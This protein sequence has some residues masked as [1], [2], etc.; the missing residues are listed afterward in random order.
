MIELSKS[1]KYTRHVLFETEH[2]EIVKCEWDQNSVSA[3]HSHGSSQCSVLVEEGVFENKTVMGFKTEIETLKAGEVFTTPI[4][5][6]HEIRCVSG[7]GKT[8]HVYSPKIKKE[9]SNEEI[10]FKLDSKNNNHLDLSLGESMTWSQVQKLLNQI[11]SASVTTKSPYFMNQLFSGIHPQTLAAESVMNRTR[12]TLATTEA[13]PVFSKIEAEVVKML[14]KKVGWN[15]QVSQGLTVAGGSAANMMAIHCARQRLHPETKML[16]N[17]NQNYRIYVSDQ[18]HYSFLKSANALG[19]G[20]NAIVAIP[21]DEN[22]RMITRKLRHQIGNDLQMKFQPLMIAAT[23]GTTVSGAF[24]P[25]NDL[26]GIAQ[27]FKIWLHIDA[28]WGAPAYFSKLKS[29]L[30]RGSEKAD[31]LTFDA[32]KFFGSQLTSTLFITPHQ[33]ILFEANDVKGGEYL[34]HESEDLDRGRIS[35]Q[36][37]RGPDVL[38]FWTLWKNLGDQG[39]QKSI[40]EKFELVQKTIQLIQSTARLKLISNPEFL[41]ICFQVLPHEGS[42]QD[43]KTWSVKVREKLIA[44]QQV[45]VNYSHNENDGYFIRMIF[46]HP[47]IQFSHV[48]M[49]IKQILEIN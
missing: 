5:A 27:D 14:A 39:L 35:W 47:Q 4:G 20:T 41:N 33:S 37:G 1:P 29:D 16:G 10:H 49:I 8:L 22:G 36:C 34:F 44:N 48:Q 30:V 6:E 32:H 12:T 3:L 25:I 40:D 7:K 21:S 45:M 46:A 11:E 24:D 19:L 9:I 38:S 17:Q 42:H 15:P 26:A 28:A 23:A 31:S 2:F 13:S 43:P 18:A